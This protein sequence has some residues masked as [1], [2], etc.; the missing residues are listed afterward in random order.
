MWNKLYFLGVY[1]VSVLI[2]LAS[3]VFGLVEYFTK[4]S[5]SSH[6]SSIYILQPYASILLGALS[7]YAIKRFVG[8]VKEPWD[9]QDG[10]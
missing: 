7:I 2:L 8:F 5:A 6:S 10:K 3:T 1:L 9:D 4:S